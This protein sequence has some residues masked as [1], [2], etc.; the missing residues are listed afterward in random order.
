M[1]SSLFGMVNQ[2]MTGLTAAQYQL[3]VVQQNVDNADTAGYTRQVVT[4]ASVDG[5]YGTHNI[6]TGPGSLGGV[7]VVSTDREDDPVIDARQRAAHANSAAADTTAT[8]LSG[9]ENVFP[10]PTDQGFGA[11]LSTFWSDWSAVSTSPAANSGAREVLLTDANS[12]VDSLH[13]MAGQLNDMVTATTSSLNADINTVNTSATQ[14]AQLNGQ[15]AVAS[16]TGVNA[17]SLLDQRDQLLDSI[18]KATGA[19][20]TLAANGTATVAIGGQTLVSG[21]T[22]S[23][24]TVDSSNQISVGGTAV[25]VSSGSI[26]SEVTSLSSTIPS[27]Q[28]QLDAVANALSDAV[29]SVQA[30]GFDINGN[31]GAA[32]FSGSGAAGIT[33]SMTDPN[34]IAASSTGANLDG[35]NALT[36]SKLGTSASGPDQVY[37][38]LVGTV[39]TA[40]ANAQQQQTV[41]DTVSSNL[42]TLKSSVSGVNY[43]EEV[44]NMLL[45]QHA[46]Q[47]SSRVL[48]TIDSMLDT[49]INH[50]G[51]VGS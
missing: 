12:L 7:T 27:Y 45:Y 26:S 9:V 21:T 43:D 16:A 19:T 50:T 42:D 10:E 29:N 41:Q 30:A 48:T 33:V 40:S 35:G 34:Q 28:S 23:S 18:S 39:A 37:I 31:A 20:V 8:T 46:F 15:I 6:Q 24:M 25:S 32:M 44:S 2:A 13:T 22:A 11:Q 36:A 47:A 1:S 38:A 4:Q 3:S 17:N 49:L 51:L 14:L 5:T